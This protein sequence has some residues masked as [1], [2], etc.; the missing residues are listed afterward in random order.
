MRARARGPVA[1]L[2]APAGGLSEQPPYER[3]RI[4]GILTQAMTRLRDEI[5]SSRHVPAGFARRTCPPRPPSGVRRFP[6][7][8]PPS[9][10]TARA[11]TAPGLAERRLS[12][13]PPEREDQHRLA[14]QAKAKARPE[15]QPPATAE[16][17][18]QKHEPA[19]PVPAPAARPPVAPLPQAQRP[20][21]KGSKKH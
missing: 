4:M 13:R 14:E 6:L 5:V 3:K 9:R 8:A 21:F 10:A 1:W 19:S 18:P 15:R 11:P 12:A 2:T 7:C 17:E 16:A 20:P